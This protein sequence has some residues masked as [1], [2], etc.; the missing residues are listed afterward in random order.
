MC[1]ELVYGEADKHKHRATTTNS[2]LCA[3]TPTLVPGELQQDICNHGLLGNSR[4]PHLSVQ[5]ITSH[6]VSTWRHQI[7]CLWKCNIYIF[8][9]T[10]LHF[11]KSKCSA[12]IPSSMLA[13]RELRGGLRGGPHLA[14]ASELPHTWSPL[15]QCP[16][17]LPG[18]LQC[19][20]FKSKLW[21]TAY[22][23]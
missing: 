4:H 8:S 23:I 18:L 20:P 10:T 9:N 14:H 6:I 15:I 1:T 19:T 5:D 13:M 21:A 3:F 22:A 12:G 11:W 17:H 2:C 16:G 7:R